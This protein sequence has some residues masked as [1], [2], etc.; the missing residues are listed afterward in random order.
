MKNIFRI[1]VLIL[2]IFST[3]VYAQSNPPKRELRAAWVASVT[4]LDWPSS[5][6]ASTDVQKEE[7][8]ILLDE[9]KQIGINTIFLQIRTE[10]DAL[11]S[12]GFDPWSYWLT[13]SQG[14]P[15]SPYYDPLEFWV[16]E[17]HKRGME[18]HA[19]FNPY[20]AERSVGSYPIAPNHV[21]IQHPDWVIQISS[22]K[23]LNPGLPMVRDYIASVIH[24]VVSRY[25]VD[26][27]HFDDY[28]YPYPPNQIT[29]Q[30]QQTFQQYPRG[31]T[32]IADWRRD[33]VNI[34]VQ[35]VYDTIQSVK[36]YVKFGI[37][38][39]GIW[40]NGVPP[41][42]TGLDAYSTIYCDAIA[43]LQNQS[44][45]YLTPQLYW[46]FGGGQDYG[47]LQ[48][49]WGDSVNAN[50]R[51]FY[52][53]HALYRVDPNNGN[54]A[55]NEIPRQ[56]RFDRANP[57]VQGGVFFRAKSF[58]A[59]FKGVT[60]SLETDLYRYIALNP[61]MN[62]KDVVAPNAPQNL[63]FERLPNGQGG[64][65]WDLP[66][67][68]SDGDSAKRYVVYRFD[69]PNVQP[70]DLED[71]SHI[72]NIEGSRMSIPGLP[73]NPNGPYY[74]V[75]TSLD[76]NYNES[77]MS[78][79]LQVNPPPVP[80]LASP[81]NGATN[82][83]D[84]ITL[85]WFYPELASIYRLQIATDPTFNSGIVIDENEIP[86]TFH[87]VTGL[88][89]LT[90]YYWRL[91]A[92]NAGGASDF[93]S[94]FNF[95]TGYPR[96]PLLYYPPNNQLNI[97][98]DTTFYWFKSDSAEAYR[99]LLAK[100]ADFNPGSVVI[101]SSGISDTTLAVFGLDLNRIYHWKIKA[102]N[103]F[104]SSPWSET[105][106][107]KT[108]TTVGVEDEYNIPE[109]Y[110][111]EQ[112]YPNPFNPS[113][114]IRFSI[115]ESGLVKLKVYNL[116]GQEVTELFNGFMR[117]GTHSINFDASDFASGIYFYQLNVNNFTSTKKMILLK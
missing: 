59:N 55:A 42:I 96:I 80:V 76:E 110:N 43:W 114:R 8:I 36:P 108:R 33:N 54:W 2:I 106:K 57:D 112:N 116:L 7:V 72:L 69:Y 109:S 28:F 113:T 1:P 107:F 66:V 85:K 30:D 5:R 75:V 115:P 81:L 78:S 89:G 40:K 86:D 98:I 20:R 15:P 46:P 88:E 94:A 44:I 99:L 117:A 82:L 104:G 62:W 87:V 90:T 79:V 11:Y 24:D 32:N 48:P 35:Q 56:I 18:I 4:N 52:P 17:T 64:L 83:G 23:F 12:S 84:T 70:T 73:P 29:N 25:D 27:V 111:L 105:W 19:W 71:P 45:D 67:I 95:T 21:T 65:K 102:Y 68:A 49:W 31:F 26:G 97:P 77:I 10:C 61:V 3:L 101:D 100:S 60:D 50:G 38:P 93:S 34:M 51:H 63:T 58:L 53:G 9:L 13:G 47:K 41:G 6:T 16:E 14:Y 92:S 103:F 22:F 39:F 74:F 37:S 91:S